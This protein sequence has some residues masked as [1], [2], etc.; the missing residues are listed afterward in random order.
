[1]RNIPE[2]EGGRFNPWEIEHV[3]E[4]EAR[5]NTFEG[6]WP[7]DDWWTKKGSWHLAVDGKGIETCWESWKG[8][9]NSCTG[10]E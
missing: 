6:G 8:E 7:S 5:Y 2:D 10:I 4:L 3:R 9:S 1:M